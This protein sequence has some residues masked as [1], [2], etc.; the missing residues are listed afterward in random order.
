MRIDK[1]TCGN[2]TN[3][4]RDLHDIKVRTLFRYGSHAC[5]PYLRTSQGFLDVSNGQHTAVPT[6]TPYRMTAY[7]ELFDAVLYTGES[8]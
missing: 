8:K 1:G 7:K 2:A 5:G 3:T 4:E 6:S